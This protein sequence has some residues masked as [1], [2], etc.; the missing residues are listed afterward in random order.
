MRLVTVLMIAVLIACL[1]RRELNVE[2]MAG[3]E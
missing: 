2:K 3:Y 1:D